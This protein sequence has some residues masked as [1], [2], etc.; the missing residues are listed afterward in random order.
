MSWRIVKVA[1]RAKL[2]LKLN[3]LVIRAETITKIHLSEI[4]VLI[5]ENTA[6]ALTAA[7]LVELTK[8][9]IKVIFCDEK[10][11]PCFENIAYY[12]SHDTSLKIKEQIA[13]EK[14]SKEKVW[15]KIVENKILQQQKVLQAHCKEEHLLLA[16]YIDNLEHNDITNREGHAAKVYFNAL[17]GKNFSRQNTDVTNAA[18]NYGYAILL[19]AFNRE[20]VSHGYLTQLGIFHDNRFNM[21][22]FGSDIMEPFRPLVDNY[23]YNMELHEFTT[24]E[25]AKLTNILNHE[26][27]INNRKEYVNNAIGIYTNSVITALNKCDP[28]LIK[29]YENEL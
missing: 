18:L 20:V 4:S 29:F 11:N 16:E 17:F 5:I 14:I 8:N 1:K 27:K 15:T 12:G 13:W 6:I 23:V 7:L 21:F 19:S 2:D 24:K 22:N 26:V 10:R 9:N 28:S 3:Y 25:K